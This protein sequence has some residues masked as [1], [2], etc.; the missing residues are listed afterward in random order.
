M[1]SEGSQKGATAPGRQSAECQAKQS[2]LGEGAFM[3]P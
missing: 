1:E 3:T 2:P